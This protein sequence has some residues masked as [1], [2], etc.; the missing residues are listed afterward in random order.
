MQW[1]TPTTWLHWTLTYTSN[2]PVVVGVLKLT[3]PPPTLRNLLSLK[4][5]E[6]NFEDLALNFT[7]TDDHFGHTEVC[8]GVVC[9]VV[10]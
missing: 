8:R 1:S 6:G 7:V 2:E 9:V 3:T 10:I 5:Y 4:H